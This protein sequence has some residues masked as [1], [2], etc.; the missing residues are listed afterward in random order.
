M[1]IRNRLDIRAD[2]SSLE[3]LLDSN[4]MTITILKSG[5]PFYT[6]GEGSDDDSDLMS[7][8][9]FLCVNMGTHRV[10]VDEREIELKNKEYELDRE[11]LYETVWG[12][13]YRFRG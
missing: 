9:G 13:G 1:T 4:G 5:Q 2:L 3:T 10:F 6:Y 7:A 8:A 11:T 12:A